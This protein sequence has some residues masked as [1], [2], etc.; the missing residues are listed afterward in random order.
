MTIAEK[1]FE[2]AREHISHLVSRLSQKDYAEFL[3]LLIS[4]LQSCKIA[5][6]KRLK[7]NQCSNLPILSTN[8]NEN[9]LSYF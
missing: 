2:A 3:D 9:F 5:S 1:T 4:Y 8:R 7:N 6:K